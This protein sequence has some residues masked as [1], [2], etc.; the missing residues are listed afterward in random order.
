MDPN[1]IAQVILAFIHLAQW[2][3][4]HLPPAEQA[5]AASEMQADLEIFRS[6]FAWFPKPPQLPAAK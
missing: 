6:W 5:K 2:R 4:D 1:V 3:L